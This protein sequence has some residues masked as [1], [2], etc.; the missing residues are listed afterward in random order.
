V[1]VI[2]LQ[3]E[4]KK[5]DEK[6]SNDGFGVGYHG[7]GRGFLNKDL[8]EKAIYCSDIST[9]LFMTLAN[10]NRYWFGEFSSWEFIPTEEIVG[11]KIAMFIAKYYSTGEYDDSRDW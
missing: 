11:S 2:D 9:E 3:K 6:S 8:N 5:F 1:L 7:C 4:H 10:D